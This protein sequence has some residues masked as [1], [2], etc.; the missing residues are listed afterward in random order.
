M[1]VSLGWRKNKKRL[2][3]T[4]KREEQQDRINEVG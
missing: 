1:V 3:M 4:E 2:K